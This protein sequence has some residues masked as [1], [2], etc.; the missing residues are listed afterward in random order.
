MKAPSPVATVTHD[1]AL[2]PGPNGMIPPYAVSEA[3]RGKSAA[4]LYADVLADREHK[5]ATGG[6]LDHESLTREMLWAEAIGRERRSDADRAAEPTAAEADRLAKA[7]AAYFAADARRKEALAG[8][9]DARRA[10]AA[11]V[12][13]AAGGTFGALD[14]ALSEWQFSPGSKPDAVRAAEFA[15]DAATRAWQ[16]AELACGEALVVLNNVRANLAARQQARRSE[17]Q[18]RVNSAG[19]AAN[20]RRFASAVRGK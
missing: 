6:L 16:D 3:A 14:T 2:E 5:R 19:L 17:A 8:I 13:K 9:D 12:T 10:L 4:E 7:E 18:G 15:A 1:D 11:A 20:L